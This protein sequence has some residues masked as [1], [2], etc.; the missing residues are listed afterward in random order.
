[1]TR[2]KRLFNAMKWLL[3]GLSLVIA[4]PIAVSA[5]NN[6]YSRWVMTRALE[7]F[8][9]NEELDFTIVS[10]Q[11]LPG[12]E[13]KC[14]IATVAVVDI[15]AKHTDKIIERFQTLN[16]EQA[17]SFTASSVIFY[18]WRHPNRLQLYATTNMEI[19][20]D[21]RCFSWERQPPWSPSDEPVPEFFSSRETLRR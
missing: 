19:N 8:L 1:M 16:D 12:P 6:E 11:I 13:L 5:A 14:G 15:E 18:V 9:V 4:V 21:P 10:A 7:T 2:A 20:F 3:I 17:A